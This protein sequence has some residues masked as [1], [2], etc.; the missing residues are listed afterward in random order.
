MLSVCV[1]PKTPSMPNANVVY[2]ELLHACVCYLSGSRLSRDHFLNYRPYT[3]NMPPY[4]LHHL[5]DLES[6]LAKRGHVLD[7]LLKTERIYVAEMGSILKVSAVSGP[8]HI[9][10]PSRCPLHHTATCFAEVACQRACAHHTR[11]SSHTHRPGSTLHAPWQSCTH[12]TKV[13]CERPSASS[14]S[15]PANQTVSERA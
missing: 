14:C 5:Q 15:R 8:N 6:R 10:Q 13:R 3:F 9:Q 4:I 7:E 11:A 12:R 2:S 1:I